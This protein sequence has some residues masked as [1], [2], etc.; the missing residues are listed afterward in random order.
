MLVNNQA[1]N[2]ASHQEIASEYSCL[3]ETL[4][5]I[6]FHHINIQRGAHPTTTRTP[7]GF[8]LWGAKTTQKCTTKQNNTGHLWPSV[9]HRLG[10]KI[11][12]RRSKMSP[13]DHVWQHGL[14]IAQFIFHVVS[15]GFFHRF[16]VSERYSVSHCTE[17]GEVHWKHQKRTAAR[18]VPTSCVESCIIHSHQQSNPHSQPTLSCF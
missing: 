5:S 15:L 1:F 17:D 4:T 12:Y 9:P 3:T 18:P 8:F 11:R 10:M 7:F 16:C 6:F 13:K 14:L 2:F